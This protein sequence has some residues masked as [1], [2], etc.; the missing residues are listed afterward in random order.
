LKL[1]VDSL[2]LLFKIPMEAKL[3]TKMDM[4]WVA[5][6]SLIHPE[7]NADYVVSKQDIDRSVSHLF[8]VSITPVMIEKHLVNSE[9]RQ[10][11]KSNPSRGGSRNRYL[12]KADR[13]YRLYKSRD[14][15]SDAWDK[16]GP[17]HPDPNNLNPEFIYLVDWYQTDYFPN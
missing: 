17:T 6:A 11:D 10:A 2:K 5:V 16:T 8:N 13:G 4:V 3:M 12:A 14:R 1:F 7:T 9:D 15:D